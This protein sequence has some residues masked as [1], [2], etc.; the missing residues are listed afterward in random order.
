MNTLGIVVLSLLGGL[1]LAILIGAVVFLIV[2]CLKLQKSVTS[3][4]SQLSNLIVQHDTTVSQFR[5][6]INLAI[7]RIN[8]EALEQAAKSNLL[9]AQR[10]EKACIAFGELAKYM[11]ADRDTI[12]TNGNRLKPD[13]YATPEPG[14]NFLGVSP[15]TAGDIEASFDEEERNPEQG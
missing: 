4:Q 2:V 13:E 3:A 7:S 14:E 10:I 9:S 12:S 1:F 6:D 11:L 5:T 8:G 15:T